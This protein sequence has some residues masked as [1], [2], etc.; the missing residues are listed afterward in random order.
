MVISFL[1][2]LKLWQVAV[3]VATPVAAA[4]IVYGAYALVTDTDDVALA[5][6]EQLYPVSVGNLSNE[7]SVN[8]AVIFP[9]REVGT[10]GTPG[11]VDEVLVEEGQVV[12]EGEVLARIDATTVAGLDEAVARAR[13]D[14]SNAQ[15]A[16]EAALDPHSELELAQAE[17]AVSAARVAVDEAQET[18]DSLLQPSQLDIAQAEAAVASA[19]LA[20]EAA[21]SAVDAMVSPDQEVLVGAD[22]AVTAAEVALQEAKDALADLEALPDAEAVAS[23]TRA[24]NTAQRDYNN[25]VADLAV[26]QADWDERLADAETKASDAEEAYSDAFFKWLGR[27]L[28]EAELDSTPASILAAWGADLDEIYSA[29][30]RT[31]RLNDGFFDDPATAWDETQIFV[32]THLFPGTVVGSCDDGSPGPGTLCARADFDAAWE[33][34]IEL[35][36]AVQST[37][38]NWA[39]ALAASNDAVARATDAIE[40]AQDSLSDAQEVPGDLE[41]ESAGAA[42]RLADAALDSARS[43]RADLADPDPMLVASL[44]SDVDVAAAKLADAEVQLEAFTPAADAPEADAARRQVAVA[45]ASLADAE[46]QLAEMT[47]GSDSLEVALREAELTSAQ[48]SLEQAVALRAGAELTAPW[49]GLVSLVNVEAGQ[50]VGR[51]TTIVELVDP[52]V[53]EV[54]G[55]VDEIDVLFVR[56]G[57]TASITMDALP[58]AVLEGSVSSVATAGISQQGVVSYP[59]RIGLD[60]PDGLSIPEGLSAVATVVVRQENGLLIPLSA[61]G[62]SFDR[63]VVRVAFEGRVEERPVVL[64]SSDDFWTVVTD[65]LSEGEQIVMRSQTATTSGFGSDFRLRFAA[66]AAGQLGGFGGGGQGGSRR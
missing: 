47:V 32:W 53:V 63:P 16:L 13:L 40:T 9:N 58:G 27:D 35:R 29:A 5:E 6:D 33:T 41:I 46:D 18:L 45:E 51:E 26:A 31:D 20:V 38:A 57:A 43:A 64:G 24:I 3:L 10:F 39:T 30:A 12:E 17:A 14:L 60:V 56:T 55:I 21:R 66:G 8:G 34:L 2:K 28:S 1:K 49:T 62:G 65:G 4:A 37:A 61:L 23:A 22:S 19:R 48:A 50:T 52:T 11:T 44:Q 36:S 54:D 59:I 7:V 42:V 15:E 25:A